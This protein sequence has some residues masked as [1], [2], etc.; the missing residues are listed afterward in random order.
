VSSMRSRRSSMTS[1]AGSSP[2]RRSRASSRRVARRHRVSVSTHL[3]GK[4]V[5][6]DASGFEP[7][8]DLAARHDDRVS[9]RA[10][11]GLERS[12]A[13]LPV[14]E[15]RPGEAVPAFPSQEDQSF[16]VW[17]WQRAHQLRTRST[18]RILFMSN[19]S[20]SERSVEMQYLSEVKRTV[21]MSL[22]RRPVLTPGPVI[23]I[24]LLESRSSR[25]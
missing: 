23:K 12:R 5:R 1:I 3:P 25:L 2:Q 18:R 15:G 9:K 10:G 22:A 24:S 16:G 17:I 8:R 11:D 7:P 14:F 13:A 21:Q 19:L 20:R 4:S 6:R